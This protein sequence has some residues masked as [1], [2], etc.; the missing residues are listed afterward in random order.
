MNVKISGSACYIPEH[1]MTSRQVEQRIRELSSQRIIP[2]I[3][4]TMTGIKTRH[5]VQESVTCSDLAVKAANILL[6]KYTIAKDSI[7]L[8]LFSS[9]GQDLIEPAT[10]H[11]VQNKLGSAAAVFDIKNAC[12]SFINALQVAEALIK[13]GQYKRVLITVGETPSKCIKWNVENRNDFKLSFPGYTFGD[14]GAAVLLEATQDDIGIFYRDFVASS[15]HWSIG[16]LPGGGSMHPRGDEYSYFR[17]DGTSLKDAFA[18]LGTGILDIALRKTGLTY[19]DFTK[20]FIHQVSMPFLDT[21]LKTAGIPRDK[22]CITLPELGNMAAAS[23]PVGLDTAFREGS[24]GKGDKIL[25]IGLAGGIS[26]GVVMV[27]L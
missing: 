4:E 24:I 21:F 8:L 9:A 25:F 23:L 6:E 16:T 19:N 20:I 17:G 27:Q 3:I 26:F 18:T 10:S 12:N 1:K 11:I 14:A 5:Y 15:E 7:D 22:V 2:N 13:M